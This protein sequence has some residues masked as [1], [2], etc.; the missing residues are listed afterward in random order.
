M[1]RSFPWGKNFLDGPDE[2]RRLITQR[3]KLQK[4]KWI[5]SENKDQQI[6]DPEE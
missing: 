3:M 5:S 1:E 2:Y 4:L 6:I